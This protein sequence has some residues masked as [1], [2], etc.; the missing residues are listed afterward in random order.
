LA[1]PRTLFWTAPHERHRPSR[2]WPYRGYNGGGRLT[3]WV[4]PRD[5][6]TLHADADLALACGLDEDDEAVAP[7][8]ILP[9]RGDHDLLRGHHPDGH[10]RAG[11]GA[12]LQFD[13]AHPPEAATASSPRR[14]AAQSGTAPSPCRPPIR[15]MCPVR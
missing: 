12:F 6:P 9:G 11:S 15:P 14:G 8:H 2:P 1:N 3:I 10:L 5:R 4:Y 7:F 13:R